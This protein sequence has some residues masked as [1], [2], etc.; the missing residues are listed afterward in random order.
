MKKKMKKECCVNLRVQDG[1]F[2]NF[3]HALKLKTNMLDNIRLYE[4]ISANVGLVHSRELFKWILRPYL[5]NIY[6]LNKL[7]GFIQQGVSYTFPNTHFY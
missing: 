6:F 4:L 7:R 3:F 5:I 2:N 1:L